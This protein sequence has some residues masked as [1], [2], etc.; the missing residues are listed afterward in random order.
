MTIMNISYTDKYA[1]ITSDSLACMIPTAD[2]REVLDSPDRLKPES[3][4]I[5]ATGNQPTLPDVVFKVSKIT[6]L[7]HIHALVSGCGSPDM[8]LAIVGV[9]TKEVFDGI[10]SFNTTVKP[11]LQETY[12]LLNKQLPDRSFGGLFAIVMW[13]KQL[14]KMIGLS[15]SHIDGFTAHE[16]EDPY[17]TEPIIN[18]DDKSIDGLR[19]KMLE[20][21]ES[22][23][24]TVDFHVSICEN[25][26]RTYEAGLYRPS[27]HCDK[28]IQIATLTKGTSYFSKKHIR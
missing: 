17:S 1:V 2:I 10:Y 11:K 9:L 15:F 25:Q 12:D 24:K 20:A 26:I 21:K 14:G 3:A 16:I 13:S 6:Y 7:P 22:I 27:W 18:V 19:S 4:F 8:L 28:E 23:A 5:G